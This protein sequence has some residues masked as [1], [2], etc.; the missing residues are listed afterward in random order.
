LHVYSASLSEIAV[1][2]FGVSPNAGTEA[3]VA[4]ARYPAIAVG[5]AAVQTY[6]KIAAKTT[7]NHEPE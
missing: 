4:A 7:K 5:P 6:N 1:E 2:A 3:Q